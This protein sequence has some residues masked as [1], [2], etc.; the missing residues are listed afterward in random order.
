MG[1]RKYGNQTVI[2]VH[3]RFNMFHRFT[4]TLFSVYAKKKVLSDI[5]QSVFRFQFLMSLLF[6]Q[7]YWTL[8]SLLQLTVAGE[9]KKS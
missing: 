8:Q 5:F 6:L 7:T 4:L 9:E 3:I 1:C 2:A